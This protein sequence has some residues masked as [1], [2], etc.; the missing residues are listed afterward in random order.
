MDL[1]VI[2]SDFSVLLTSSV[3]FSSPRQS[4]PQF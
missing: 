4:K 3:C 2:V 1:K